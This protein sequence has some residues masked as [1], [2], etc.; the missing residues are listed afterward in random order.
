MEFLGS[1][2]LLL[3]PP[4]APPAM[5]LLVLLLLFETV[6]E[7]DGCGAGRPVPLG[8][9]KAE[10]FDDVFGTEELDCGVLLCGV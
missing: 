3:M 7:Q 8:G 4:P 9:G 6:D 10:L 5:L 2:E 1:A